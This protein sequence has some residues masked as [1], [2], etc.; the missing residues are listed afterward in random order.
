MIDLI[1]ENVTL[2]RGYSQILRG[3]RIRCRRPE[4]GLSLSLDGDR[5]HLKP[6]RNEA[7][8]ISA[9]EQIRISPLTYY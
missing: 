7:A 2:Y 6:R 4:N 3:V 9:P 1:Y 5:V 8:T